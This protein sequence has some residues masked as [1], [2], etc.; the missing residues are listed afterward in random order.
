MLKEKGG[1]KWFPRV[2]LDVGVLQ[3]RVGDTNRM[4]GVVSKLNS[5]G[6]MLGWVANWMEGRVYPYPKSQNSSSGGEVP[7]LVFDI[8]G[9]GTRC[10]CPDREGRFEERRELKG[11]DEMR[12]QGSRACQI[13]ECGS[14][15]VK[16][17][18]V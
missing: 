10:H 1:T 9:E 4:K 12:F 6:W 17:R 2:W 14:D 13:L 7:S 8:V 16:Y 15:E 3:R 11:C 5:W 18:L